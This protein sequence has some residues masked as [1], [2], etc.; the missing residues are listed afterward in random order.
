MTQPKQS[1]P[2]VPLYYVG[3]TVNDTPYR[4]LHDTYIF[5]NPHALKRMSKGTKEEKA[6]AKGITLEHDLSV[7]NV[8]PDDAQY[9]IQV[10][11]VAGK[12]NKTNAAKD[13]V[14]FKT[15]DMLTD[16]EKKLFPVVNVEDLTPKEKATTKG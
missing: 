13:I 14:V 11:N 10:H 3:A 15:A 2:F 5:N 6:I 1:P 4:A 7:V 16:E 12:R 9:L 8:H